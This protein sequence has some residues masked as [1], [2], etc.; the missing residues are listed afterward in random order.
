MQEIKAV[1]ETLEVT[2]YRMEDPYPQTAARNAGAEDV[3][4]DAMRGP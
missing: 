1:C 4:L 2:L 3:V